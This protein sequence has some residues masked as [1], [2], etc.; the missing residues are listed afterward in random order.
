MAK[1]TG[2]VKENSTTVIAAR[3]A[4]KLRKTLNELAKKEHRRLSNMIEVLLHEAIVARI[5]ARK[6]ER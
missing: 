4:P 3:V 5:I 6:S 2:E 1:R